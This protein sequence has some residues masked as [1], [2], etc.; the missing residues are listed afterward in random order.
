MWAGGVRPAEA[1]PS[2]P[3]AGHWGGALE[4]GIGWWEVN[5][6]LHVSRKFREDRAVK[7]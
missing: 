1:L 7:K 4:R 3:Q 2:C 5:H 6:E